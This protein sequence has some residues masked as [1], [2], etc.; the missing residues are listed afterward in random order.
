MSATVT[1]IRTRARFTPK[2]DPTY[3]E[4]VSDEAREAFAAVERA[5]LAL[6]PVFAGPYVTTAA[7]KGTPDTETMRGR[8]SAKELSATIAG[9]AQR[10]GRSL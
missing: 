7:L 10:L 2:P 3:A 6:R 1:S 5:Y 9:A 4:P 8:P